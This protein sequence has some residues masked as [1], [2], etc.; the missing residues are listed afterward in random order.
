M[1]TDFHYYATYLAARAAGFSR[2][3]SCLIASYAEI[4]DETWNSGHSVN[5]F[6]K[7]SKARNQWIKD[8]YSWS[9]KYITT[10]HCFRTAHWV[11]STKFMKKST[12]RSEEMT[13][14]W[15]AFHF[16]PGLTPH[17]MYSFDMQGHEK[18]LDDAIMYQT[19]KR[20]RRLHKPFS[21]NPFKKKKQ[22]GGRM[23][24]DSTLKARMRKFRDGSWDG[25]TKWELKQQLVCY[26]YS[27]TSQNMLQ[28]T[29]HICK[30]KTGK[31]SSL[32]RQQLVAHAK[33]TIAGSEK[34]RDITEKFLNEIQKRGISTEF[35]RRKFLLAL[36][37][38]RMHVFADT[39]A[40]QGFAGVRSAA[41]ND[42]KNMK[43]QGKAVTPRM[44]DKEKWIADI[45]YFGHGRADS[46]PDYPSVQYEYTRPWDGLLIK[47]N[48]P[49]QFTHA[50][51]NM[52]LFLEDARE[53]LGVAGSTKRPF[54]PTTK[55]TGQSSD[56]I[57]EG[58]F[59]SLPIDKPKRCDAYLRHIRTVDKTSL[60]AFKDFENKDFGV[61][62]AM[63]DR[64][65]LELG[66]FNL[67]AI[68][69]Q[70]WVK[71]QVADHFQSA[72]GRSDFDY[73][74]KK[75]LD[76]LKEKKRGEKYSMKG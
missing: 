25:P 27:P 3:D 35:S 62:R 52:V 56:K 26:P 9:P 28:D 16:L 44:L 7:G 54:A 61:I 76:P 49:E 6:G 15:T 21:H 69:H 73:A 31:G 43:A 30:A 40:H 36:I 70:G 5:P 46:Y 4:V 71:K 59:R 11:Y 50:Y 2:E 60:K 68:Y 18:V 74:I 20:D 63:Y 75:I 29:L 57:G 47:R 51:C 23:L 53:N 38:L 33:G 34:F 55:S 32:F 45:S 8:D 14:V 10:G 17:G 66:Y 48:N 39:F 37:G 12:G 58:F 72:V 64:S 65:K 41:I 13:G 24:K 1:Q 42:V 19:G 67:A 22:I